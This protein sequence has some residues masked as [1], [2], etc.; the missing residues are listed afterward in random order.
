MANKLV[1]ILLLAIMAFAGFA[2]GEQRFGRADGVCKTD[3]RARTHR[4]Q[5]PRFRERASAHTSQHPIA[6]FYAFN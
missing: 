5:P 2:S 6:L 1:A 3:P 4:C